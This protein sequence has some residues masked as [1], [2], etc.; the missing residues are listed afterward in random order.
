[1]L[2]KFYDWKT[3]WQYKNVYWLYFELMCELKLL[4]EENLEAKFK[5][6]IMNVKE[7]DNYSGYP[8]CEAGY[9]DFEASMSFIDKNKKEN[10]I[11]KSYYEFP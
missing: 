8:I 3:T 9:L 1:M 7:W 4:P 11:F 2:L 10:Y 6:E 5:Y